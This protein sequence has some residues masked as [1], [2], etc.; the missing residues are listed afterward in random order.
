MWGNRIKAEIS[1]KKKVLEVE[2]VF[3]SSPKGKLK[4]KIGELHQLVYFARKNRCS[5]L[6]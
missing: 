1:E 3:L 2:L 6:E 5:L 4:L